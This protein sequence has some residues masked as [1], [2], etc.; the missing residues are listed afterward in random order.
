MSRWL[1]R[2]LVAPAAVAAA[3]VSA[4]PAL[5]HPLGNFT[6][7]QY[8]GIVVAPD[9][10]RVS[11]VV[12][13]AEVPTVQEQRAIDTDRDGRTS[14]AEGDSYADAECGRLADE[15][16]LTIDGSAVPL[17]VRSAG[18]TFPPGQAGLL[19][20]RLDCAL[21]GSIDGVRAGSDLTFRGDAQ[22]GRLG[23]REVTLAGDGV[24]V[25]GSDVPATSPSAVLTAYPENLLKAP[26]SVTSAS[27]SLR[28]G[29]PRLGR[30]GRIGDSGGLLP[31]GV[32]RLSLRLT[33]LVSERDLTLQFGLLA[34]A[35]AVGL[36]A[37]HALSPGHGKTVMAAYL[38]GQRGTVR[39]AAVIGLTVTATHTLGVV[40]LGIALTVSTAVAPE[41]VIPWLSVA[42]GLLLAVIGVFLLR[43]AT[44]ALRAARSA[45]PAHSHDDH[46]EHGHDH[47][48]PHG[49]HEHGEHEHGEHEH[50]HV[51]GHDHPHPHVPAVSAAQAPVAL[52]VDDGWHE[53]GGSRHRH[54]PI[55][56]DRP[57]HW[58]GLVALGFAG[59]LVPSPSALVV[60]LGAIALGRAWFGLVLVL[61]FGAGMAATLVAAG[62]LLERGRRLI[63]RRSARL[64]R[65]GRRLPTLLRVLPVLTAVVVVVVGAT[66]AVRGATVAL[67]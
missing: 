49:D 15:A 61:G 67:G 40:A 41:R 9:E 44:R 5:A 21:V 1:A 10:V 6:V 38:V 27:A 29:G 45:R 64:G 62:L 14:A 42:S 16:E 23:W 65:E 58:R 2:S 18:V 4:V 48:H 66:L 31:R 32:D 50:D 25:V 8:A 19:T 37:L 28:P 43:R 46:H 34:F 55:D 26:L 54:A 35:I 3:L 7:N 47:P 11:R 51:A 36:G 33:S 59:G 57:L 39:Q 24:T 53:H 56:V 20:L 60:L 13:M 63:D 52:A 22:K 17:S 12:D 30:A